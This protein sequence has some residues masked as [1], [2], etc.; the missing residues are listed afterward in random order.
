MLLHESRPV[1]GVSPR[2]R[3]IKMIGNRDQCVG[4][5]TIAAAILG[6]DASRVDTLDWQ[7]EELEL[8]IVALARDADYRV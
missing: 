3:Y 7:L 5:G 2:I 1:A 8:V 4:S 6:F